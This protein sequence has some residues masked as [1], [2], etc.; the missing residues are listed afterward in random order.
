MIHH[1]KPLPNAALKGR[2]EGPGFLA[3]AY[4]SE[5]TGGF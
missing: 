1:S 4:T 3:G 5:T 2:L